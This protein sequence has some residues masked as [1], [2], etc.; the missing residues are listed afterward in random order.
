MP[1]IFVIS[2]LIEDHIFY[3]EGTYINAKAQPYNKTIACCCTTPLSQINIIVPHIAKSHSEKMNSEPPLLGI[4]SRVFF[5]LHLLKLSLLRSHELR[6]TES[7]RKTMAHTDE[8][9]PGMQNPSSFLSLPP[10]SPL[11]APTS[12]F[13]FV[14]PPRTA[15][16]TV[17]AEVRV[18]P[19][20]VIAVVENEAPCGPS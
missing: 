12:L 11:S 17:R 9:L 19:A 2:F 7:S 6:K 16:L 15:A 20:R 1:N 10:S 5:F 14:E 18:Q 3:V 4:S 13:L 8:K